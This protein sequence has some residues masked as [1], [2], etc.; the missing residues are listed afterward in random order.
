[1]KLEEL[2]SRFEAAAAAEERYW[3]ACESRG[4][5]CDWDEIRPYWKQAEKHQKAFESYQIELATKY[6]GGK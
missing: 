1:M 2:R 5:K 6:L 3:E 4:I